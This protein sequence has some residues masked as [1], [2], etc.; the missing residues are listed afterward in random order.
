MAKSKGPCTS[1]SVLNVDHC[2]YP[3]ST[4]SAPAIN[5]STLCS[6]RKR[7]APAQQGVQLLSI[8]LPTTSVALGLG[9]ARMSPTGV[10]SLACAHLVRAADEVEVVL[11]EKLLHLRSRTHAQH[12]SLRRKH[13]AIKAILRI[14]KLASAHAIAPEVPTAQSAGKLREQWREEGA[15]TSWALVSSQI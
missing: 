13:R 11:V 5:K 8:A 6:L 12:Q 3:H 7:H 15:R 1:H 10:A 4:A 9:S 2:T 14:Q